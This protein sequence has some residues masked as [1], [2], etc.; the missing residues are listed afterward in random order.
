[1]DPPGAG[2]VQVALAVKV[3][4]PWPLTARD[5]QRRHGIEPRILRARMPDGRAAARLPR[6]VGAGRAVGRH[7]DWGIRHTRPPRNRSRSGGFGGV[8]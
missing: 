3:D 1:V 7:R 4:Q 8:W 6:R 5:R 2:A